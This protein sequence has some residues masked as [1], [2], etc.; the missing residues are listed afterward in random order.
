MEYDISLWEPSF[1]HLTETSFFA[2]LSALLDVLNAVPGSKAMVLFSN[3]PSPSDE[4]DLE[5]AQLAALASAARCS[6]YPVHAAGLTTLR[7]G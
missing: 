6:V 7:P 3:S 2:G 4:N 5:F 1:F